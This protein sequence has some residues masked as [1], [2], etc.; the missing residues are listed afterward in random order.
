VASENPD[1]M[2]VVE[3][4]V[5]TLVPCKSYNHQQAIVLIAP[6]PSDHITGYK[7]VMKNF[8]IENVSLVF[9]DMV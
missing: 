6:K 8:D 3:D 1:G 5:M 9:E 7:T 4:A 2:L